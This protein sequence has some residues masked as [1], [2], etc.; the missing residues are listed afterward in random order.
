MAGWQV[1]PAFEG[2]DAK[3]LEREKRIH[4]NQEKDIMKDSTSFLKIEIF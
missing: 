1:R 2:R 4:N 3:V